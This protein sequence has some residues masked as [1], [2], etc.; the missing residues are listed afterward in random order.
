[1]TNT[2]NDRSIRRAGPG[3]RHDNRRV[4]LVVLAAWAVGAVVALIGWTVAGGE[5]QP[6]DLRLLV[7]LLI[8][9]GLI[10]LA[11]AWGTG[12]LTAWRQRD[13]TGS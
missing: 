13:R 2:G 8:I 7:V 6:D 10:G 4:L 9:P 11:V 12:R 3:R 5:R 1:M